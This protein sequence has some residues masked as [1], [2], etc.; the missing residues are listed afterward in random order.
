[1]EPIPANVEKVRATIERYRAAN[2]RVLPFALSDV[3]GTST[4]F[5]SAGRPPGVPASDAWD[6]GNKSSSLLAPEKHLEVHPW[7]RFD[8][9]IHV[10]TWTLADVCAD[11]GV[12]GIDVIHM[13]VQGAELK[14]LDGA[15]PL[16]EHVTAIWLEVEAVP[17]YAGQPLKGDVEGYLSAHGFERWKDTVDAVSGDQL[18]VREQSDPV[19]SRSQASALA[20]RLDWAAGLRLGFP[21]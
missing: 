21:R 7:V 3:R 20:R 12:V 18:W 16:L 8:E 1:V 5:V 10:E 9:V 4:M 2:V 6:Y 11:R 17:L 19:S 14:V 15:G 13:D